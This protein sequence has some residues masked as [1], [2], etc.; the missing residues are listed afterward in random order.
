M[1]Q[2]YYVTPAPTFKYLPPGAFS[3]ETT[4]KKQRNLNK[5][6]SIFRKITSD[7]SPNNLNILDHPMRRKGE[8]GDL[9]FLG[10]NLLW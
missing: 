7:V 6:R 5:I 9:T 8:K 4:L 1:P 3:K 10:N 2:T